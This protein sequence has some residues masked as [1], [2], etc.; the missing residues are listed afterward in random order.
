MGIVSPRNFEVQV[1]DILWERHQGQ[2]RLRFIPTIQ[3]LELVRE[4]QIPEPTEELIPVMAEVP[5]AT[6]APAA[7]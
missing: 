7:S 2:L 1:G 4:P 5:D 3:C 6:P